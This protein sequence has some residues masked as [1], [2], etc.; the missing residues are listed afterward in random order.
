[1]NGT[2]A[3]E[4][5]LREHHRPLVEAQMSM[6][7]V[8]VDGAGGGSRGQQ[9]LAGTRGGSNRPHAESGDDDASGSMQSALAEAWEQARVLTKKGAK[10]LKKE[11]K[12]LRTK[13]RERRHRQKRGGRNQDEAQSFNSERLGS[14]SSSDADPLSEPS[15]PLSSPRSRAQSRSPEPIANFYEGE[16]EVCSP[17]LM[18]DHLQMS[19][20]LT[21]LCFVVR[22][23]FFVL[24]LIEE[25]FGS[26]SQA[27]SKVERSRQHS[28][29]RLFASL[30]EK[31][32]RAW[33]GVRGAARMEHASAPAAPAVDG[34]AS[35][36]AVHTDTDA[37]VEGS[38]RVSEALPSPRV[39]STPRGRRSSSLDVEGIRGSCSSPRISRSSSDISGRP[40]PYYADP[41]RANGGADGG[42]GNKDQLRRQALSYYKRQLS[43]LA[44]GKS[45]VSD[46][47]AAERPRFS[48][49]LT[50][51]T[52]PAGNG[53]ANFDTARPTS[54]DAK[55]AAFH[56]PTP[57]PGQA[58]KFYG[59]PDLSDAERETDGATE[60]G[61]SGNVDSDGDADADSSDT[62][63]R[64]H[65]EALNVET[66]EIF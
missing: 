34:N 62:G 11:A 39:Q 8:N 35:V 26:I 46:N 17:T 63:V 25:Y 6:Q 30:L 24:Q 15:S 3:G 21:C 65:F 38:E 23:R 37:D 61:P 47:D 22:L 14:P 31:P 20:Q 29:E 53:I 16:Y 45:A 66:S 57:G 43:D 27:P 40:P 7:A 44:L 5:Q 32:E 36:S 50:D 28:R 49:S 18:L 10:K 56:G 12:Q 60:S 52:A 9:D 1:M 51:D 54:W 13:Y 41:L 59:P 19:A 33:D 48:R 64:T 42:G 55:F 2:D 58:H 4:E